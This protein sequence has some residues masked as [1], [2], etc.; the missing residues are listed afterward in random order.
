MSNLRKEARGRECQVRIPGVCS[1]NPET[2]VLAHLNGAGMGI[3]VPDPLGAW[4]CSDCHSVLDGRVKSEY[5]KT[6]LKLFHLEGV[7]RT[8]RFLI[9][10]GKIKW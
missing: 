10:E 4:C 3:K 1:H 2:V 6:T 8:L 7:M 5:P 9:S